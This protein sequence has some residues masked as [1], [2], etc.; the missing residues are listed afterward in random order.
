MRSHFAE[1]CADR[2]RFDA[3]PGDV[4]LRV[5]LPAAGAEDEV[6]G[7][8]AAGCEFGFEL[9]GQRPFERREERHRASR[10]P[11]LRRD[12]TGGTLAGRKRELPRDAQ[13]AIDKVNI[14]PA[15]AERLGEPQ[16]AVGEQRDRR[17]VGG[18]G[19]ANEGG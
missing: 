15:E 5:W 11:R 8:A 14:G 12:D 6:F 18:R 9:F 1:S 16:A 2:G 7:L 19:V 13:L 10:G 3:S 4:P 17:T